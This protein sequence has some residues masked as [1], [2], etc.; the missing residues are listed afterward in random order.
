KFS[1]ETLVLGELWEGLAAYA[2]IKPPALVAVDASIEAPWQP[3]NRPARILSFLGSL[4][5]VLLYSTGAGVLNDRL[6][7]D[8]D[9]LASRAIAPV[10]AALL[11]IE[12]VHQASHLV[13]AKNRGVEW[14]TPGVPLPSLPTGL[15]GV[16]NRVKQ[17]PRTRQDMFDTALVGPCAGLVASLFCLGLGAALGGAT[18]SS[19]E[20]L[21][22]EMPQ[23]PADL[24]RGS[25]LASLFYAAANDAAIPPHTL[26]SADPL[27]VA[28]LAGIISNACQTLPL[29]QTDGGR[30]TTASLGKLLGGAIIDVFKYSVSIVA[31]ITG[32]SLVM[33]YVFY[34][35]SL[36][37]S[38]EIS[39]QDD[40]TAPS[41]SSRKAHA[42]CL[43]IA[44]FAL[45]PL[46]GDLLCGNQQQMQQQ[47]SISMGTESFASR[48]PF[49]TSTTSAAANSAETTFATSPTPPGSSGSSLLPAGFPE[50]M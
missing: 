44:F 8:P 18:A 41:S 38:E 3:L 26:V 43:A 15:L 24:I 21:A 22:Q 5:T 19:S 39:C 42:A 17:H 28:G 49:A 33:L 14:S 37:N 46:P 7:A 4:L 2:P 35:V 34:V 25:V 30:A 20:L 10:S 23:L 6:I 45:I 47:Q 16:V 13:V 31:L 48:Q 32:N 29:G 11:G 1:Q 9:L 12:L 27:F 50:I 40:V 36:Q